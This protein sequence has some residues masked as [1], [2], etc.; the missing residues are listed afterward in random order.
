M[1]PGSPRQAKTA[2]R[3]SPMLGRHPTLFSPLGPD[4]DF[5]DGALSCL[6]VLISYGDDDYPTCLVIIFSLYIM[7]ILMTMPYGW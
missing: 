7:M 5:D 3:H 4:E 6:R 1:V 2:E